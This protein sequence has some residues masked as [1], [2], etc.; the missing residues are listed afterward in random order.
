MS[1]SPQVFILRR[2]SSK[3]QAQPQRNYFHQDFSSMS[4]SSRSSSSYEMPFMSQYER[5]EDYP[6]PKPFQATSDAQSSSEV[7]EWISLEDV[8]NAFK[9]SPEKFDNT[10]IYTDTVSSNAKTFQ[11]N[12]PLPHNPFLS[13]EDDR[14]RSESSMYPG[15]VETSFLAESEMTYPQQ[16]AR[17][18]SASVSERSLQKVLN[19]YLEDLYKSKGSSVQADTASHSTYFQGANEGQEPLYA[20]ELSSRS[21][22]DSMSSLFNS[23]NLHKASSMEQE[24]NAEQLGSQ[25]HYTKPGSSTSFIPISIENSATSPFADG[26]SAAN[27]AAAANI[28]QQAQSRESAG[29]IDNLFSKNR[30]V[31]LTQLKRLQHLSEVFPPSGSYTPY[32]ERTIVMVKYPGLPQTEKSKELEIDL[33]SRWKNMWKPTSPQNAEP[34]P[35]DFGV[36]ISQNHILQPDLSAQYNTNNYFQRSENQELTFSG[37]GAD[38]VPQLAKALAERNRIINTYSSSALSKGKDIETKPPFVLIHLESYTKK[39]NKSSTFGFD[40]IVEKNYANGTIIY[41]TKNNPSILASTKFEFENLDDVEN[42][43]SRPLEGYHHGSMKPILPLGLADIRSYLKLMYEVHADI[44]EGGKTKLEE[45]RRL[46]SISHREAL[47]G[48]REMTDWEIRRSRGML[49]DNWLHT[50]TIG[51]RSLSG[52]NP[53]AQI[54]SPPVISYGNG[55]SIF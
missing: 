46:S 25:S 42:I 31:K 27:S 23:P 1:I 19:K 29:H 3:P 55:N 12:I 34:G 51:L 5:R 30:Q 16:Q 13:G 41:P 17:S 2:K 7:S 37:P 32:G 11:S 54:P 36:I 44:H 35:A 53:F 39:S 52:D 21:R 8:A 15:S 6:K 28:F 50:S 47:S 4:D 10:P 14:L 45:L 9:T 18:D 20:P 26:L 40:N 33:T 43:F 48:S 24:T 38:L 49:N 22:T